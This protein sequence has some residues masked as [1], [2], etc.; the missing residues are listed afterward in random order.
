MRA[1]VDGHWVATERLDKTSDY[2]SILRGW[3]D[4]IGPTTTAALAERLSLPHVE[5]EIALAH[6]EA[7]GQILRGSWC[8]STQT[9]NS[10]IAASSRA[11]IA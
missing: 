5:V 6:L 10:A 8:Q 2:I 4:S 7:E 11:F 3:M 9:P 1:S